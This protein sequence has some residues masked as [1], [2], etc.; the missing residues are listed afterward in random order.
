MLLSVCLLMPVGEALL[1][2]FSP[3]HSGKADRYSAC[4]RYEPPP[5]IRLLCIIG[6]CCVRDWARS[7]ISP[8]YARVHGWYAHV[9]WTQELTMPINLKGCLPKLTHS[10]IHL[11]NQ[12][13]FIK[14]HCLPS[15]VISADLDAEETDRKRI[16]YLGKQLTGGEKA[17]MLKEFS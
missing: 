8:V 11:F 17:V 6:C 5:L 1:Y 14:C 7:E 15:E 2:I 16:L 13:I 3:S 4:P 10:W 9:G 12:H